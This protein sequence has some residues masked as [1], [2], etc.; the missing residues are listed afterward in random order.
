MEKI[1]QY[2]PR[3]SIL[4]DVC[5]EER[6]KTLV[7]SCQKYG[8][9][10][11]MFFLN[12]ENVYKGFLTVDEI[13]REIALIKRAKDALAK[14]GIKTS[15]NPWTTLGHDWRGEEIPKALKIRRMVDGKGLD[16]KGIACPT[17][18]NW[19]AYLLEYFTFLIKEIQPEKIWIEDDFRM[20]NHPPL[21]YGGCFCEEHL[22]LYG[23][24]L[25]KEISRE[26]MYKGLTSGQGNYRKAFYE[27]NRK[28]M[29]EVATELGGAIRK[30]FP[31]LQ[32]AV[33]TTAPKDYS[34]EGRDMQGVLVGWCGSN[35][36][37]RINL[38]MYRQWLAQEYCW[39]FNDNSIHS[40]AL[41]PENTVILSEVENAMFSPYNKSVHTTAFQVETSLALCPGGVT[42]DIDGQAGDGHIPAFGYGEKLSK[43]KKYLSSFLSLGVR[44][45]DLKG[46]VI[47]ASEDEFLRADSVE[48]LHQLKMDENWWASYFGCASIAFE[49]D[50]SV[51]FKDKILAIA[52]NYLERFTDAEV[53]QLFANNFILLEGKAVVSLFKRGLQ[54]LICATSYE[55]SMR[56]SEGDYSFE[57]AVAGKKYLGIERCRASSLWSC[58]QYVQIQYEREKVECYTKVYDNYER[59]VGLGLVKGKNF[60]V[61]PY[62]CTGKENLALHSMR[63]EAL[64]DL[65]STVAK[66]GSLVYTEKPYVSVYHYNREESSVLLLA[67]F[68]DDGYGKLRIFGFDGIR[69][70]K[71]LDRKG[72]LQEI[73]YK[74]GKGYIEIVAPLPALSTLTLQID[75]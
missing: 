40:R 52:D 42:L 17:C 37:A 14:A 31:N 51:T 43:I 48:E 5:E 20:R 56:W 59:E 70:V 64:K 68:S 66:P 27:V 33:M 12:S 2:I 38:P 46:I 39:R 18:K 67:N 9:E 24:Y 44:F 62:L 1:F 41:M 71:R 53:E 3:I 26:E 30:Q 65:L 21:Y 72:E 28:I 47:P 50:K 45:S 8:Y 69:K 29:K 55:A 57:E 60:A 13:Q 35:P 16:S 19:Q 22:R 73:K 74:Q 6:I 75:K 23:E 54:H 63:V 49:Y 4:P 7:T 25:G 10:E 32:I 61:F 58:P 15:L 11:V 34:F 36:I